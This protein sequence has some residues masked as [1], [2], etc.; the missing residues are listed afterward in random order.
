MSHFHHL[1]L[2]EREQL[3]AWRT[4]GISLREIARRLHRSQSSL[5]RELQRNAQGVPASMAP[6]LYLP[7]RAQAKAER[8]SHRQH[9][10]APQKDP[11]VWHYVQQRLGDG[12]SP[13]QIAG[14]YCFEHPGE[15]LHH[16]TIY[17][18]VYSKRGRKLLLDALLP[19]RQP[20]R[21]R[22]GDRHARS[23]RLSGV[24]P[25]TQRPEAINSRRHIGDWETDTFV[26]NQHERAAIVVT[27][28]RLS[29]YV[30]LSK[31][32]RATA[33]AVGE[34]VAKRMSILPG[35]LRHSITMDNGSENCR[36]AHFTQLLGME[37]YACTPY[38]AWEKGTVENTIGRARLYLPKGECLG[39]ITARQIHWLEQQLNNTP[40]K[41]LGYLTPAEKLQQYVGDT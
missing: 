1:T 23:G 19:R 7:C 4:A 38:H 14:R 41:C 8:R 11:S 36:H 40:R 32:E 34:A 27:V 28:E 5:T 25:I 20:I 16:E 15:H 6:R 12:W 26:G 22:R 3:F 18:Y 29:R 35:G 21:S 17:R 30:M 9:T 39:P 10:K 24:A 2:A 13:E 31:V 37:A 33:Q